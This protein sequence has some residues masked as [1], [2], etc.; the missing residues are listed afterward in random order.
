MN[1]HDFIKHSGQSGLPTGKQQGAPQPPVEMPW[2]ESA[3]VIA[4]P[5]AASLPPAPVDMLK[6]VNTRRSIRTFSPE[7]LLL[8]DLSFLL[9]CTQGVQKCVAN[10]KTVR[11]VPS[12]GGAHAFET[13]VLANNVDGVT[14]GLYR[15]I[16]SKHQ[17]AAVTTDTA[18]IDAIVE[19]FRNIHL[20]ENSA[21]VF[22][23]LAVTERMTWRFGAR[24]WRYLFLDA[25]HICQNLYLAAES[26]CCGA[27]AIGSFD[28]AAL[29]AALGLDGEH[30]IALYAGAVGR[31]AG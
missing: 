25:G 7:P 15:F 30:E 12:A 29:N 13:L 6:T 1:G 31:K 18:R 19:A 10:E 16:A 3:R 11:T 22:I 28:D 14:P 24:G 2:D 5:D 26:I 21:A 9:W 17:L 8:R 4:L 27:C 23:W 20:I